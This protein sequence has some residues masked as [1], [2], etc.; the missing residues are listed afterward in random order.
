MDRY[1]HGN[2]DYVYILLFKILCNECEKFLFLLVFIFSNFFAKH[3][4]IFL[5]PKMSDLDTSLDP[6]NYHDN[7][8]TPLMISVRG[9]NQVTEEACLITL[10]ERLLLNTASKRL[11]NQDQSYVQLSGTTAECHL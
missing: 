11:G 9:A 5:F 2:T 6:P 8:L 7:P 3:S 1:G 4:F 10:M